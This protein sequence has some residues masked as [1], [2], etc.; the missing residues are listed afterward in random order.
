[1]RSDYRSVYIAFDPHPSYK[2]AS[3]HIHQMC[4][5]LAETHTPLLLLTLKSN[6]NPVCTETIH[7]LCFE[8]DEPNLLTRATAFMHWVKQILEDQHNLMLGHYRDIW[9]GMAVLKFPHIRAV[10]EVNG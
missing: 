2:G 5:V 8:S 1:M 3:T 10:Y 9:G 4:A 6:L 7:Q